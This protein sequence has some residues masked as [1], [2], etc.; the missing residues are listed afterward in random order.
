MT[1]QNLKR[2]DLVYPELSYDIIGC[3]YDVWDELGPGHLEKV[4]QKA[5]G[6]AL[7]SRKI[8]FSEQVHYPLK[9]KGELVGK[10]ILDFLIEEMVIVEIKKDDIF[11]KPRIEQVLNYLKLSQL[12]LAILINFG[13]SGVKFKRIVNIIEVS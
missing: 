12:K 2:N 5:L 6:I 1:K 10:G 13:K 11:S 4:Y 9:F 8:A 7:S 3:V